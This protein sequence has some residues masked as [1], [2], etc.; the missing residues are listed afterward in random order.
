MTPP[1]ESA[2]PALEPSEDNPLV[3]FLETMTPAEAAI[4]DRAAELDRQLGP[5]VDAEQVSRRSR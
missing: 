4:L 2:A 3:R 1:R 5:D